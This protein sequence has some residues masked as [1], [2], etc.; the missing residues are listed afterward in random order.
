[1]YAAT[2]VPRPTDQA[3]AGCYAVLPTIALNSGPEGYGGKDPNACVCACVRA[4]VCVCV[5]V[6]YQQSL[7]LLIGQISGEQSSG[8]VRF[9]VLFLRE[10][11][12][13][14]SRT[15]EVGGGQGIY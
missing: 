2:K 10:K 14:I 8:Q 12:A 5:C 11:K 3:Q 13:R 6:M 9:C 1:M 7:S 15:G 4:C